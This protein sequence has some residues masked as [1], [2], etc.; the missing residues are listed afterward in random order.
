MSWDFPALPGVRGLGYTLYC[1]W[2][3]YVQMLYI[4]LTFRMLITLVCGLSFFFFC[5]FWWVAPDTDPDLQK[6]RVFS[7][8]LSSSVKKAWLLVLNTN[9]DLCACIVNKDEHSST[10]GG[11]RGYY[12]KATFSLIMYPV[13]AVGSPAGNYNCTQYCN[14]LCLGTLKA[15]ECFLVESQS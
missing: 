3:I 7:A 6:D 5:P 1:T 9:N 14:L 2:C 11:G 8:D 10:I 4:C 15:G 13:Y 12:W